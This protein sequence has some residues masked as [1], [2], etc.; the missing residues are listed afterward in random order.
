M[1]VPALAQIH[2]TAVVSPDAAVDPTVRIGP[3]TVIEGPV[4]IGPDCVLG[5][6]VHLVG[7][8]VLGRGNRVGTGTVMRPSTVE[9]YAREA[10]FTG[11]TVLPTQ[12]EAFRFY[13][14]DP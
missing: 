13:R 8:L 2:P 14:L 7:P 10:G 11:F 12:H 6:F 4:T 9:A 1:P 5:P 3:Y